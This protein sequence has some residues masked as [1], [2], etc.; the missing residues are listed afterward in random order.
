MLSDAALEELKRLVD[1]IR[2]EDGHD[3][4]NDMAFFAEEHGVALIR[5]LEVARGKPGTWKFSEE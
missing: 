5:E 1:G 2:G 3:Y 4:A